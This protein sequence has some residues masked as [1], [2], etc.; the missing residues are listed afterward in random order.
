MASFKAETLTLGESPQCLARC[1]RR[2]RSFSKSPLPWYRWHCISW[3]SSHLFGLSLGK[4]LCPPCSTSWH[5]PLTQHLLK[6]SCNQWYS[7]CWCPPNQQ[8]SLL[9]SRL[10]CTTAWHPSPSVCSSGTAMSTYVKVNLLSSPPPDLQFFLHFPSQWMLWQDP[11]GTPS[12][13]P[14]PLISI[15]SVMKVLHSWGIF[16][17]SLGSHKSPWPSSVQTPSFLM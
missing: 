1:L 11:Q 16:L 14:L 10:V 8:I 17:Q 12:S 9:G 3:L 13:S 5:L 7:M 4:R 2:S 15:Y 6:A